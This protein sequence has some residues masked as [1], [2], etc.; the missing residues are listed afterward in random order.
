MKKKVMNPKGSNAYN[1]NTG[2]DD[3]TPTGSN[4]FPEH[5]G[6][7]HDNPSDCPWEIKLKK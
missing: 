5:P 7:K 1:T 2:D 4:L 3:T 6:Y